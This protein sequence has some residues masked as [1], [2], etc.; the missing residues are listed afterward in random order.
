MELFYFCACLMVYVFVIL[1][2]EYGYDEDQEVGLVWNLLGV[3]VICQTSCQ[4]Q[5]NLSNASDKN[6]IK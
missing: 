1:F 6:N 2:W 3:G 4:T 5:I